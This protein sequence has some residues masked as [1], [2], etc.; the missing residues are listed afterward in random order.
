MFLG[1]GFNGGPGVT[2]PPMVDGSKPPSWG[3]CC[4]WGKGHSSGAAHP[5]PGMEQGMEALPASTCTS[6]LDSAMRLFVTEC[7]VTHCLQRDTVSLPPRG[8]SLGVGKLWDGASPP[9]TLGGTLWEQKGA[10]SGTHPAG[11]QQPRELLL[12]VA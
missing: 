4:C 8:L 12:L 9:S 5:L 7:V 3:R 11:A 1:Q 6:N 10:P 2:A